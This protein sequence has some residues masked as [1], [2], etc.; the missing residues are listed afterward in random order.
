MPLVA[1][2]AFVDA[3]LAYRFGKIL[4][5]RPELLTPFGPTGQFMCRFGV[6]QAGGDE[7]LDTLE[8]LVPYGPGRV[9]ALGK[10]FQCNATDDLLE[11][12]PL[13]EKPTPGP[14]VSS[15]LYHASKI[16]SVLSYAD[17]E[18]AV[19]FDPPVSRHV[20]DYSIDCYER[21]PLATF[22]GGQYYAFSPVGRQVP[23]LQV[24][25][26]TVLG[27]TYS[28][29]SR[30]MPEAAEHM[31]WLTRLGLAQLRMTGVADDPEWAVQATVDGAIRHEI[32]H[33]LS[34]CGHEP[35]SSILEELGEDPAS[36]VVLGRPSAD[37]LRT[38]SIASITLRLG[39]VIA[40]TTA[41]HQ[42]SDERRHLLCAFI[43]LNSPAPED[44]RGLVPR[45]IFLDYALRDDYDGMVSLLG[46]LLRTAA[47]DVSGA[48]RSLRREE[49]AAWARL[50]K[51]Y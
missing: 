14:D 31:H 23:S 17:N 10:I 36:H 43:A 2:K 3:D 12:F 45:A 28:I 41:W 29:F 1:A 30:Q 7:V 37:R 20:Y 24:W 19:F 16:H 47:T 48:T 32:G 33:T 35:I 49:D 26:L 42:L 44:I 46:Q 40:N 6:E 25:P 34:F 39:D 9:D 21:S 4:A 13:R 8:R 22:F 11:T 18:Y 50:Q 27:Y 51:D 15:E 5:A 38:D